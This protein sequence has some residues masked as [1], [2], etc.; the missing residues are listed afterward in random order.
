[1]N[2]NVGQVIL[3]GPEFYL[4]FPMAQ[5]EDDGLYRGDGLHISV[6]SNQI[7]FEDLRKG[8]G[9]ALEYPLGTL[10]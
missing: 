7:F 8:L 10:G 5:M 2:W 1:M 3:D 6:K 4:P 9:M